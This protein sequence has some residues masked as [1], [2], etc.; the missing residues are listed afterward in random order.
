MGSN[1]PDPNSTAP[2]D[3][4]INSH[5]GRRASRRHPGLETS[6]FELSLLSRVTDVIVAGVSVEKTLESV[7]EGAMT[8]IGADR[9]SIML[10]NPETRT[11]ELATARGFEA[12]R[13]E[14]RVRVGFGVAGTVAETGKALLVQDAERMHEDTD[15]VVG[16]PVVGSTTD[17]KLSWSASAVC[18]PLK[19]HGDVLGVLNLS[20]TTADAD[21]N[22]T[23]REMHLAGLIANQA[24]LAIHQARVAEDAVKHE[25][26]K[27]HHQIARRIQAQFLPKRAPL[28]DGM[29]L[30]ASSFPCEAIGGDFLDYR[31]LSNG[32]L[33]LAVGDVSGHGIGAALIMATARAILRAL[34]DETGGTDLARILYRMNNLL[35]ED[36]EDERFMTLFV[37]VY[38]PDTGALQYANAGHEPAIHVDPETGNVGELRTRGFPLGM[39][40]NVEYNLDFAHL[41]LGDLLCISTDGVWEAYSDAGEA[42]GRDRLRS[43]IQENHRH[44]PRD[45][46]FSLR[47]SLAAFVGQRPMEDDWSIIIMRVTG[48]DPT[49][50]NE[51]NLPSR[52]V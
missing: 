6:D 10:A 42:F 13:A 37:A 36:T 43:L 34:V 15:S 16:M 1:N 49:K 19:F 4:S 47:E 30:S 44:H 35:C 50:T 21:K 5:D 27:S 11:L 29:E 25:E 48:F 52:R 26:V 7:L 20:N 38:D 45:I 31:T 8:L 32:R 17:S 23:S 9:G 51:F 12:N 40:P 28:F 41:D 33:F 24:A 14:T 18:V 22:F 46:L 2:S 39:R 3:S